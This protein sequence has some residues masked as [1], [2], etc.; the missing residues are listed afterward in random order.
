M[1]QKQQIS[2]TASKIEVK[3]DCVVAKDL[4]ITGQ[5][6]QRIIE[7]TLQGVEPLVTINKILEFG[8]IALDSVQNETLRNHLEAATENFAKLVGKE[9][10]EN[11]PRVIEEKTQK[12]VESILKYLDPQ[13]TNS[14]NSQLTT[15]LKS[16]SKDIT[17]QVSEEMKLQ[18]TTLDEGLKNLGFLKK[19]FDSS[20]QKGIPHQ[21]YVGEALERFAGTDVVTDLSADSAG[22]AYS[23]GRSRSGDYRVTLGETYGTTNAISFS[24]EAKNSKLSEKAALKEIN[25]NCANRG[26]D[27][28]IL[29]FASQEQAPTQGRALKIFPGHKIMVV[30]DNGSETAL[31]AAYVYARCMS[32][33][34][35]SATEFDEQSLSQAIEEAIK[36]L[37]IEDAVN[38]DAKAA[39]NAIDRLVSTAL[40]A[41]IN[42]L[43][44]LNQFE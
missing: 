3:T 34:L 2:I 37:D 39:R 27:V 23:A 40:T 36:Y 1:T 14:L 22:A 26:T 10:N 28:G 6:A 17:A 25:E 21:D 33:L 19:A 43:K 11:F 18:K 30:C 12:F 7:G 4:T 41:R 20:T 24:V 8:A 44:V 9:A 35:N 32:K 13:Q 38:K 31:Y 5:P 16:L 29:V 15:A 42:V